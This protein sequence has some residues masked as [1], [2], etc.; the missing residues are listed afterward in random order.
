MSKKKTHEEY[1]EELS[2]KNPNLEVVGMYVGA[3]TPISHRCKIDEYTWEAAPANL[4]YGRGCP[5]CSGKY[6]KTHDDYVSELKKTSP[7]IEVVGKYIN[8]KTKILHKCLTHNYEWYITPINALKVNGCKQCASDQLS[9]LLTKTHKEYIDELLSVN[10]NIE[11]VE[12]YKGA[13]TNIIHKCKIHNY[14]WS[15]R[16]A[17]ILSGKGCPR[18]ANRD[19]TPDFY[20]EKLSKINPTVI[21]LENYKRAVDKILHKCLICSY[22]WMV[23]PTS[24]LS[25]NGCPACSNSRGEIMVKKWLES[26][27]ISYEAQKRFDDCKDIR[28]LPFDFYLPNRNTCIEYDGEQHFRPVGFRSHNQEHASFVFERTQKHDQIKNEYCKNK[29]IQLIRIPYFNDVNKELD[30]LLT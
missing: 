19:V 7:N 1:V 13:N 27:N 25:G 12:V 29:G 23:V 3:N 16:P 10:P 9:K 14:E 2:I 28:T 26:H 4:L 21:P 17:N 11:A 8:A 30:L 5:K 18:C 24:L 22:E 6:R 20:L 15:A